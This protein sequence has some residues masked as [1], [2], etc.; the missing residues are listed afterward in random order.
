MECP[1]CDYENPR[2]TT[3]CVECGAGLGRTARHK[4]EGHFLRNLETARE[5]ADARLRRAMT[6]RTRHGETK[7]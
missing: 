2:G 7:R 5:D 1:T 4:A 3:V 6:R